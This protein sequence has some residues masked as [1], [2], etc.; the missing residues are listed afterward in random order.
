MLNENKLQGFYIYIFIFMDYTM[1]PDSTGY[2]VI[3]E[4]VGIIYYFIHVTF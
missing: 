3:D 2:I 1:C 4:I